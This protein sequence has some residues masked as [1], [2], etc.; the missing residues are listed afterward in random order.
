MVVTEKPFEQPPG[1][2]E[3]VPKKEPE[4]I[5][6]FTLESRLLLIFHL[7]SESTHINCF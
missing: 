3:D 2:V 5:K 6:P 1:E 7:F 4:S